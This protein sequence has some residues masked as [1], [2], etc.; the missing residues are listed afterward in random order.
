MARL[1]SSMST[2]SHSN[3]TDINLTRLIAR[4]RE[5]LIVPDEATEKL[6]RRS[7]LERERVGENVAYA[8]DLLIRLEQDALNIKVQ[9]RRQEVQNDL[10]AKRGVLQRFQEV[11]EELNEVCLVSFAWEE[12]AMAV[13]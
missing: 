9:S 13:S 10:V 3:P 1:S 6:L 12:L 8:R 7:S 5:T 2:S 11:L 4:L